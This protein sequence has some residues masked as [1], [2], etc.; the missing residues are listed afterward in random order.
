MS[1]TEAV[2]YLNS[3][4]IDAMKAMPPS[5]HRIE[6]LCEAL[7]HP[8]ATVPAI[9][10]TGTN[11]KTSTVRIAAAVLEATDL[12]VGTYTSPHLQTIRERI[13]R[14]NVPITKEEFGELFGHL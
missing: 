7:D 1:F 2:S 10:V 4:G 3:L 14:G 12:R 8:E 6:A 11:G 5:L 9:H 13:T